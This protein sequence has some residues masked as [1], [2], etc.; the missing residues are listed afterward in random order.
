MFN[1]LTPHILHK[2]FQNVA[3][4]QLGSLNFANLVTCGHSF[5]I[6]SKGTVFS[7]FICIFAAA[8]EE[9]LDLYSNTRLSEASGAV[10]S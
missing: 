10:K 9:L 2:V 5:N 3:M 7:D 1:S 4:G 6:M 8:D